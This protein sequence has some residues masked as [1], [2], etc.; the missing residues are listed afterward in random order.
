MIHD[1]FVQLLFGGLILAV[2]IV[3]VAAWIGGRSLAE[4]RQEQ[5]DELLDGSADPA[6]FDATLERCRPRAGATE[7]IVRLT[8]TA[9]EAT[10]FG[11]EVTFTGSRGFVLDVTD[12]TTPTLDPDEATTVRVRTTVDGAGQHDTRCELLGINDLGS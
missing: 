12:T 1:R 3:A 2:L 6:D 11:V 4:N 10:S 5:A 7:A 9:D 8:N